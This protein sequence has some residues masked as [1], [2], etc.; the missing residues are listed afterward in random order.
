MSSPPIPAELIDRLRRSTRVAVLTGAGISAESGVP[1]FRDAVSGLWARYRPEDLATPE[2][3]ARDPQLVWS[4][5]QWR[6]ELVAVARPNPGHLALAQLERRFPVW[7]LITQNVDDLHRR[8][9]SRDVV[10]LHGDIARSVCSVEGIEVRD[11]PA[12]GPQPPRCPR[13]GAGLRPAVVWFGED[14]PPAAI[15]TAFRAAETCELF[16]CVGTSTLVYPA[17]ELP[18]VAHRARA[19][20]VEINPDETPL[21]AVADFRLAGPAGA[22]LPAL[23]AALV[24]ADAVAGPA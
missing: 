19:C 12:D 18:F 1:T 22:V 7:T 4:W 14:L 16:L 8:A 13:C 17:A 24:A 3:Y 5:Y 9:G 20:V 15:D 11:W 21:S 10:A 2:A 6:R 23:V